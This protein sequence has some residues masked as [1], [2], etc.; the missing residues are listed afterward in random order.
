MFHD[1]VTAPAVAYGIASFMASAVQL[2]ADLQAG[3][4][5]C[6]FTDVPELLLENSQMEN[7]GSMA[8]TCLDVPAEL[9]GFYVFAGQ[10]S[11][12]AAALF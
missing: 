12:N 4:S 2:A 7:L 9:E 6:Y 8:D 3:I 10:D 11:A 1:G 5:A